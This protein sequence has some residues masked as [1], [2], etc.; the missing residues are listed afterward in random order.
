MRAKISIFDV[1][2]DAQN[3]SYLGK[4][5]LIRNLN[6]RYFKIENYYIQNVFPTQLQRP[7]C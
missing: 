1:R 5:V 2:K 4:P 6:Y 7:I 3:I